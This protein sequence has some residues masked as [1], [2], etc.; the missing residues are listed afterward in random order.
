MSLK[1]HPIL[2]DENWNYSG[3]GWWIF[4]YSMA[5]GQVGVSAS[6]KHNIDI[7]DLGEPFLCVEI[8]QITV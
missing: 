5:V 3:L 1:N 6:L 2:H 7:L 8:A 4:S